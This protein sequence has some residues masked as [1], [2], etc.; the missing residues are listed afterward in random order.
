MVYI[1]VCNNIPVS[2]PILVE[3]A[4]E[5]AKVLIATILQHQMDV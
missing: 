2:G 5:F 3:K 1:N 4:H